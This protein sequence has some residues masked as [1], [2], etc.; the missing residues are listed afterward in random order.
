MLFK[1][2]G[3]FGSNVKLGSEIVFKKYDLPEMMMNPW[4]VFE[5]TLFG[6]LLFDLAD[7][8]FLTE[9]KYTD[10]ARATITKELFK[11]TER[12]VFSELD[13][14][15]AKGDVDRVVTGN[16]PYDSIGQY[17]ENNNSFITII[18]QKNI[19]YNRD[20]TLRKVLFI[21][22]PDYTKYTPFLASIIPFLASLAVLEGF[23]VSIK[24]IFRD[25]KEII[26]NSSE[27]AAIKMKDYQTRDKI[28]KTVCISLTQRSDHFNFGYRLCD[29]MRY[30]DFRTNM[31]NAGLSFPSIKEG[32][33]ETMI[34][35]RST[36]I[37]VELIAK[38]RD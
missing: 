26:H 24:E 14:R 7:E 2:F 30:E 8:R 23:N 3:I 29:P 36:I 19:P 21:I 33:Y 5:S 16:D 31:I 20:N 38:L 37:I 34:D 27:L 15:R 12:D 4:F 9:S 22:D 32:F 13:F 6:K 10:K 25:L 35:K 28:L 17:V 11:I 1:K 18:K